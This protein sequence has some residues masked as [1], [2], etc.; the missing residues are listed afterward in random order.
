MVFV[1]DRDYSFGILANHD[2]GIAQGITWAVGL[3]L[4]DNL[5]GLDGQVFGER[6]D[7]LM[8]Q[9]EIQVFG[10]EQGAVCVMVAAGW[11]RKTAVEIF[12]KLG[13]IGIASR[14]I[15]DTP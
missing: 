5:V 8:G 12:S 1:E 15:R 13:Q 11:Y 2:F 10:L 6:A 9:D 4:V 3:D 7:L 14:H